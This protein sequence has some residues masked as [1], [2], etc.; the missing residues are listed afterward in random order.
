MPCPAKPAANAN[1]EAARQH[2][3]ALQ[4]EITERF[5]IQL[6]LRSAL[7]EVKTHV[8]TKIAS[9]AGCG[10]LAKETCKALAR[11]LQS[12]SVQALRAKLEELIKSGTTADC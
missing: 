6:L 2:L 1:L 4:D 12:N 9:S 10:K 5:P 3:R 8:Q 11:E 7:R